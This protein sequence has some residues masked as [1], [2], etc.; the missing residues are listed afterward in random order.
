MA[1][2]QDLP[3]ELLYHIL[4]LGSEPARGL[5]S[6]PLLDYR[7]TAL[8]ARS[9]RRPSQQLLLFTVSSLTAAWEHGLS[10]KSGLFASPYIVRTSILSRYN[11]SW[12][13]EAGRVRRL[14]QLLIARK[15]KVQGL[16]L[17][18]TAYDD[19]GLF[20]G[21]PSLV[22]GLQR[23]RL[24]GPLVGDLQYQHEDALELQTLA[25]HYGFWERPIPSTSPLPVFLLGAERLTRLE[26]YLNRPEDMDTLKETLAYVLAPRLRHLKLWCIFTLPPNPT[27][28]LAAFLRACTSLRSLEL[29]EQERAAGSI[30]ALIPT[31]LI[32]LETAI[33]LSGD[34]EDPRGDFGNVR[35]FLN[36]PAL[37]DLKRWRISGE[38]S[39]LSAGW[40]EWAAACR[41]RG[42]EPRGN[43]R[44][45]TE[46]DSGLMLDEGFV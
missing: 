42:I 43:E 45:Y 41:A 26:L 39:R 32:L 37:A 44:Y 16:E 33:Y 5:S 2:I 29:L 28:T 36:L 25:L 34:G 3:P 31:R 15:V 46:K 14:L 8:V 27:C 35:S 17:D 40:E 30:L 11:A 23:L 6:L 4:D 20:T 38:L 12:K 13:L 10:A 24:N 18:T 7:Q 22:A 21:P 1:V 19:V 9:W